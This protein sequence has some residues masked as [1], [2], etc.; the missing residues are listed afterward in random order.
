MRELRVRRAVAVQR[1]CLAS[2]TYTAGHVSAGAG[3]HLPETTSKVARES[4]SPIALPL[5][6]HTP[7]RRRKQGA[8][9]YIP[10][11]RASAIDVPVGALQPR[12]CCLPSCVALRAR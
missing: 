9:A 12:A 4:R 11:W 10:R 5:G 8:R 2:R 3:D 7:S 1:L 6:Q